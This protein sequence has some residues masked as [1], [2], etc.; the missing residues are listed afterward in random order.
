MAESPLAFPQP[1]QRPS[2][3]ASSER[4]RGMKGSCKEGR[5]AFLRE[6]SAS[7]S[8]RGGRSIQQES[9][10]AWDIQYNFDGHFEE[11]LFYFFTSLCMYLYLWLG[12]LKQTLKKIF[13]LKIHSSYSSFKHLK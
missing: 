2:S 11:K 3:P 6:Q 9:N 12:Y 4:S 7:N 10:F 5:A 13:H 8:L 1:L